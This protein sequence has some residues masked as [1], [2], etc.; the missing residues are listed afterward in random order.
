MRG[1]FLFI[2]GIYFVVICASSVRADDE[3]NWD[4][5]EFEQVQVD[6]WL[7]Y[8]LQQAQKY[9]IIAD[10]RP[11]EPFELVNASLWDFTDL[12]APAQQHGS[13]FLWTKEGRPQVV[14]ALW[15]PIW[16]GKFRKVAH[17]FHSV[18]NEP[19]T[20]T[21]DG[22]VVWNPR[23]KGINFKPVPDAPAVAPTK[24]LRTAQL[25]RLSLEFTGYHSRGKGEAE[26]WMVQTP[27][28]RYPERPD[29]DEDGAL[30]VFPFEQDPEVLLLIETKQVGGELQW[31]F[32][33][34]RLTDT[35][36]RLT[37]QGEEV[38]K[39]ARAKFTRNFLNEEFDPFHALFYETRNKLLS[40][41][42]LE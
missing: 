34:M 10:A 38:W 16:L 29:S 39:V 14:A 1:S 7:T 6:R 3:P 12:E 22:S 31:Q 36:A 42:E 15:S 25:R 8:Y 2:A 35:P 23:T 19:L 26:L 18:T 40:E 17:E 27:I 28:Y 11:G 24:P 20:A 21:I 9:E 32:S 41:E 5:P 30:F 33:P 13:I 37:F 4:R